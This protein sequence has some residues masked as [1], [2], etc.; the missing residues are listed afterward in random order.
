MARKN[1]GMH[2]VLFRHHQAGV[3]LIELLVVLVVLAVFVGLGIPSF[4]SIFEKKRLTGAA[5]AM[6]ADFQFARAQA[7]KSNQGT[8]VNFIEGSNWC[9]GITD[10]VPFTDCVCNTASA[11]SCTVEGVQRV[12]SV[13]QFPKITLDQNFSANSV[14]FD[15]VRGGLKAGVSNGTAVF[16]DASGLQVN[17]VLSSSGRAKVCSPTGYAG[18]KPCS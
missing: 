5:Q 2:A 12:V 1:S 7:I 18:Y 13:T 14:E 10:T 8:A 17:A 9:Y 6:H 4:N 11:A 16:E 15:P 3:T